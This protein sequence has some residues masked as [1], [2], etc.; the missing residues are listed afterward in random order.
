ML[1]VLCGL[2][3]MRRYFCDFLYR[4]AHRFCKHMLW[5]KDMSRELDYKQARIDELE[6]Q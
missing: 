1:V 5:N 3:A 4:I 2:A 6:G